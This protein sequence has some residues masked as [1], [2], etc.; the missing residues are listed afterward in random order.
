MS[1]LRYEID[2][3]KK[4]EK[5]VYLEL[6]DLRLQV[7]TFSTASRLETLF[8]EKYGYLPVQLGQRITTLRLPD[9][10]GSESSTAVEPTPAKHPLNK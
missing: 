8:Q 9:F 5:V 6:E 10:S 1:T 3:L 7:A 4:K 2:R